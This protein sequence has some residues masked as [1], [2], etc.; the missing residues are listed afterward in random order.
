M[1]LGLFV[2]YWGADGAAGVQQ[3]TAAVVE[4]DR[5][6]YHS[7]WTA[8]AYGSDA[9]TPLAWFAA[10][11]ESIH[12]GTGIMQMPARSPAMTAMTA[13]TLDHLSGGRL[14]LGLGVSGPQV[15]EGWHGVPYGRP[16][17]RTREYVDIVRSALQRQDPVTFDGAH[18]S[19]PNTGPGT[20]GLG[21]PLKLIT[22][23]LR[24]EI[25]VYLA[26]VGPKNVSL[27]AELADGW[28]PVFYSPERAAAAR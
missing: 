25:P 13:M 15:V 21:T 18:Y 19:L 27:A 20:T 16:L 9:A 4:A 14:L 8:E 3:D 10:Q 7:V 22:H 11:T 26:A 1:Q 23:P 12:L 17:A 2:G 6:G 5:L 24:N 28:L